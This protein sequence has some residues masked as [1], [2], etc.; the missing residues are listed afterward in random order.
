MMK[1]IF[2]QVTPTEQYS[3]HPATTA[4]IDQQRQTTGVLSQTAAL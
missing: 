4:I 2:A 3:I 1:I